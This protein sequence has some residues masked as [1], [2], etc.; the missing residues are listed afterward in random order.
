MADIRTNGLPAGLKVL[1]PG[2][3]GATNRGFLG[4]CAVTL[5]T[6]DH[7]GEWGL[8]DT[9]HYSDRNLLLSALSKAGIEPKDIRHVVLSHLHFDHIL[10]LPLFPRAEVYVSQAEI[11]YAEQVAAGSTVDHAVPDFWEF[12]LWNRSV[13]RVEKEHE[14]GPGCGLTVRPGHTPGG[15]VML[16]RGSEN[17]AVCGDVIKNA[18]EAASGRPD[19]AAS[20]A[21]A[22]ESIRVVMAQADVIIP[23]H[24]RPFR[25][26]QGGLE[27]LAPF[28]WE[29][30][31]NLYPEPLNNPVLV[32]ERIA[33]RHLY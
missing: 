2:V 15:I 6:L 24:D 23:G 5:F 4:Y 21:D 10:N 29:V 1:L 28:Q 33:A 16:C 7:M 19:M 14:L 8:F 17:T 11:D 22:A 12:L 3:P 32:M 26:F 13:H 27:F 18:W 25:H 31:T 9:G 20:A 30:R